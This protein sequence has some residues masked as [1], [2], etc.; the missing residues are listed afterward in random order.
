MPCRASAAKRRLGYGSERRKWFLVAD[1]IYLDR[2]FQ[3]RGCSAMQNID[4]V[5]LLERGKR[6][7]GLGADVGFPRIGVTSVGKTLVARVMLAQRTK[8]A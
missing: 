3:A 2:H 5:L 7:A 6:E 1:E 8:H 4:D